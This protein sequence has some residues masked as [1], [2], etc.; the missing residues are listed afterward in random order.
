M[1]LI[2]ESSDLLELMRIIVVAALLESFSLCLEHPLQPQNSSMPA[3]LLISLPKFHPRLRVW[4][5]FPL[6][7]AI[8]YTHLLKSDKN[9]T[10][11][12]PVLYQLEQNYW[13]HE[14]LSAVV[15]QL[16]QNFCIYETLLEI[17]LYQLV[18]Q[19]SF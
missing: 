16:K 5:H 19:A 17:V 8:D 12:K 13:V 18:N 11:E 15:Y 3:L 4:I 2:V 9:C 1:I 6:Y 14:T 7:S 10:R